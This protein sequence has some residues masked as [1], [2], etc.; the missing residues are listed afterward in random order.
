MMGRKQGSKRVDRRVMTWTTRDAEEFLLQ[1]ERTEW[2]GKS[3][4]VEVELAIYQH[5]PVF[6]WDR[7]GSLTPTA[8]VSDF[9]KAVATKGH[10]IT[11]ADRRRVRGL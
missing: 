9:A 11:W 3:P 10:T 7:V 1:H 4:R 2:C 6:Q 8:N 5:D